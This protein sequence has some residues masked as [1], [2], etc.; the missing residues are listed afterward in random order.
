M[1][2]VERDSEDKV[3]FVGKRVCCT[4]GILS[5]VVYCKQDG[6]EDRMLAEDI[7]TVFWIQI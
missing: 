1:I 3:V 5:D 2:T 4:C 6:R 7:H